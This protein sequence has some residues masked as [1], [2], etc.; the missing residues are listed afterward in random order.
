MHVV[1]Q[2]VKAAVKSVYFP[3]YDWL[4]LWMH[5]MPAAV[6]RLLR[7]LYVYI[8]GRLAHWNV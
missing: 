6:Y 3:G 1:K 7:L 2:L 5:V 8:P 4:W